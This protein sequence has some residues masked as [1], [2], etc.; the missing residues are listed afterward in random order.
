[1]WWLY[2]RCY[3]V[4]AAPNM[5]QPIWIILTD[6]KRNRENRPQI[7]VKINMPETIPESI[8]GCTCNCGIVAVAC[9][10]FPWNL[11]FKNMSQCTL[12]GMC[13]VTLQQTV[14]EIHH[15]CHVE[16]TQAETVLVHL[17]CFKALLAKSN[18][19]LLQTYD[20]HPIPSS[21]Q[22]YLQKSLILELRKIKLK[23][24]LNP[25]LLPV[26]LQTCLAKHHWFPGFL[27][28]TRA[29][30]THHPQT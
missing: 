29:S 15:L 9:C 8:K 16:T 23:S 10:S 13:R 28:N 22:K 26:D 27:T 17:A 19:H 1:M 30:A 2:S 6:Q 11:P 20:H 5:F 14:R 21:R 18:Q 12:H 4:W 25:S 7:G 3:R 24:I